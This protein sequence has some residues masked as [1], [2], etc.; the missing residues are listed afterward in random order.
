MATPLKIE[1]EKRGLSTQ[2]IADALGVSQ[3][4]ISRIENGMK[5]ASP[6]L[7]KRIAQY[8]GAPLTYDQILF[9]EE[10]VETK[11]PSRAPRREKAVA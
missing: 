6:T 7:A 9:P 8:L 4:T 1:R 3:P 10:Y 2:S 5:R 11:K